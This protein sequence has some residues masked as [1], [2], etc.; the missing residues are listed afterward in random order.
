VGLVDGNGQA[1]G[2][3][4]GLSP[5]KV[6]VFAA[7]ASFG[8]SLQATL[9]ATGQFTQVDMVD[10]SNVTPT[11]AQ[12]QAYDAV[13]VFTYLTVTT[14]FGDNLADYFESGGG[15]VVFDYECQETGIY[16]LMGRFET[17]YTLSTPISPFA[18][19]TTSVTLGTILEPANPML[20]GVATF[21]YNGF[22]PN[23]LPTSSYTKNNP[24][25]VAQYSD[26]N[27]A[28]VRA[29]VNNRNL[30]EI[31]GFGTSTANGGSFSYGWDPTTDGATLIAQALK[32]TTPP[33]QVTVAK[34]V[35]FGSQP[36]FTPS[37]PQAVTYTNVSSSAQTITSLSVTG[38][39]IGDFSA[40]PSMGLPAVI[41]AGM[42]FVVN[43]SFLPSGLGLRGATLNATVTGAPGAA[44]TL[45]TGT[46]S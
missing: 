13:A 21:G 41:P 20:S 39:H 32:Y 43:V 10:V 7:D 23:H 15:V 33:P 44:T 3:L 40:V 22:S 14:A 4:T 8:A 5:P 19:L 42:T 1:G 34:S 35:T 26:G 6:A 2:S 11:L 30:V 46:G 27:P 9:A 17:Q 37:A 16:G 29:V 18:W 24:I 38:T 25:V 28:V 45:L 36:L 31:N 12:M